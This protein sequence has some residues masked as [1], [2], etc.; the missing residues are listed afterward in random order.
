MEL[1]KRA[2]RDQ[3]AVNWSMA[4]SMGNQSEGAKQ[5]STRT[6]LARFP[7]VW[8]DQ[9]KAAT[10]ALLGRA[11]FYVSLVARSPCSLF[12]LVCLFIFVCIALVFFF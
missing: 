6:S 4:E 3:E 7:D 1:Y 2:E 8:T 9:E 5:K 11:H 12:L 10:L